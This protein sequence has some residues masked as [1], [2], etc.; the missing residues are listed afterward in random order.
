MSKPKRVGNRANRESYKP[1]DCQIK[2]YMNCTEKQKSQ[3]DQI[4]DVKN[5]KKRIP[6]I[7]EY[8]PS[9]IFEKDGKVTV[10][11][12][13]INILCYVFRHGRSNVRKNLGNYF[14][15][16]NYKNITP[17]KWTG[18]MIFGELSNKRPSLPLPKEKIVNL[19]KH[20]P[21]QK[22]KIPKKV[23]K[24]KLKKKKPPRTSKILKFPNLKNKDEKNIF[25]FQLTN[26]LNQFLQKNTVT[27]LKEEKARNK[28][29]IEEEKTTIR[30]LKKKKLQQKEKEKEKK[31]KERNEKKEKEREKD[32]NMQ[33]KAEINPQESIKNEEPKF[34]E[35]EESEENR[36]NG[37]NQ[38]KQTPFSV[39]KEF[40]C[41]VAHDL[42]EV[43]KNQTECNNFV[44]EIFDLNNANDHSENR[45]FFDNHY[46]NN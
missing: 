45:N 17:R 15:S 24:K 31:Q 23:N 19:K 35:T 40:V 36:V 41:D 8:F 18:G 42:L 28:I 20:K 39:Q 22:K 32:E 30:Q 46:A 13:L 9:L 16:L 2:A 11:N 7:L 38:S 25:H 44:E 14:I 1:T 5:N 43:N 37:N 6:K 10:E 27:N 34:E 33:E 29:C 26:S 21:I 4:K 12:D 3:L